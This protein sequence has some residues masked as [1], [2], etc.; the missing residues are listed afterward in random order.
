LKGIL[1]VNDFTIHPII[2]GGRVRLF[3]IYKNISKEFNV[4]YICLGDAQ[5]IQE[6]IISE[7]FRV[8][9]IPKKLLYRMICIIAEKILRCPVNDFIAL[10]LAPYNRDLKRIIKDQNFN[11]DIVFFSHPYLYPAVMPLIAKNKMIIYEALNVEYPL[12][13]SILGEGIIKEIML[14]RLK[15][16]EN[17]LLKRCDLC[18]SMSEYDKNQLAQLYKIYPSKIFVAPNGVNA[19]DYNDFFPQDNRHKANGNR[20]PMILFIGSGHPP[21]IIAARQIIKNI[22][23]RVPNALFVIAGGVC[24]QLKNEWMGENVKLL[25]F[26]PDDEKKEL[27]RSTDIAINPMMSGSGTNL[28]MLDYMAAGIPVISTPIGARGIDIIDHQ[29]ALVC[30]ILEFP[31]QISCLLGD[32]NLYNKLSVNGRNLIKEKYEWKTIA[33]SI[34]VTINR[35]IKRNKSLYQRT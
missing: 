18:F 8:V 12:K 14:K 30:E 27:F 20:S 11:C 2:D 23:P 35:E 31:N 29:H 5:K 16:T 21:N 7:N 34:I 6:D 15:L 4:K 3:N 17:D 33:C 9:I 26:L 24:V 1:V 25:N 32:K 19:D 22:A 28:K 13:K 10:F